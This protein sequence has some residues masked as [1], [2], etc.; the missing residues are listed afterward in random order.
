MSAT[1]KDYSSLQDIREEAGHQHINRLESLTGATNG[2]N[3]EFYVKRTYIVDT[4]YDDE[5]NVGTSSGDVIVYDDD[6]AVEVSAIEANTGKVTLSSAPASD[7]VMLATYHHSVLSDAKVTKYR[8][9]AIS[10]IQRRLK[11]VLDYTTWDSADV[12]DEIKTYTRMYAAGLI[13]IRDHGLN[14]D[15]ELTSKDGYE[16]LKLVKAWL[17]GYIAEL[18]DDADATAQVSVSTKS[19]GNLF[20]RKEDLSLYDDT[21]NPDNFFKNRS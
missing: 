1:V 8:N 2:S 6:V 3:T 14:T 20:K 9:E 13:L 17:K 11:G 18:G 16:K 15:T 12:P 10:Y 19:D 21:I 5:L 7:S 4:N